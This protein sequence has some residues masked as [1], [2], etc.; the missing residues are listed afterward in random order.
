MLKVRLPTIPHVTSQCHVTNLYCKRMECVSGARARY[1]S[2]VLQV[3]LDIDLYSI[4]MVHLKAQIQSR[5]F[6]AAIP[7]SPVVSYPDPIFH[8]MVVQTLCVAGV[9]VDFDV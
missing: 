2:K 5:M 1:E 7:R 9:S 4:R 8:T 3:G 6:D